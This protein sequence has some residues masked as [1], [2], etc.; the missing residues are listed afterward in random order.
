MEKRYI[1]QET[2]RQKQESHSFEL[3]K[4]ELTVPF[5]DLKTSSY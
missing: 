5:M 3:I 4:E 2:L 1:F